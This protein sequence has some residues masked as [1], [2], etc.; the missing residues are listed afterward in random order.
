MP[1]RSDSTLSDLG[2]WLGDSRGLIARQVT[3]RE[4]PAGRTSVT[5]DH[6][7]MFPL[8]GHT[9]WRISTKPTLLPGAHFLSRT[10]FLVKQSVERGRAIFCHDL[11]QN[12][13]VSVLSYH[14]D[15]RPAL[16]LLILALGFRTD[17]DHNP[18]LMHST[19]AGALVL[20]HHLHAVAD[21]IGR[22]GNV[23][24]DLPNDEEQ[25]K[26]A[27]QLGFRQAPRLKGFRPSGI[28]LRQSAPRTA[29]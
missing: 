15:E 10:R 1:G 22:D 29:G 16:P 21:K 9:G 24:I 13:V 17:A 25:V 6:R 14:I 20:K 7:L 26:L 3:V 28:H 27:R 2:S 19:L 5:V 11:D 4:R 12:E 18:L 8:D 23:D